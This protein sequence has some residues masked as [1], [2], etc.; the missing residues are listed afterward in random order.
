M[1]PLDADPAALAPEA[2]QVH[3]PRCKTAHVARIQTIVDASNEEARRA[4]LSGSLNA[5]T[6]PA[7]GARWRVDLPLLYHDKASETALVLV[8]Q[9]LNLP[10]DEQEKAIGKLA[11]RLLAELPT[12]SRRMYI[13]QPRTFISEETFRTAVLES[14][15]ISS[16]DLERARRSADLVDRLLATTDE[17]SLDAAL[18]EAETGI[19]Y[20]LILLVSELGQQAAAAG[21]EARAVALAKLRE[22]LVERSGEVIS[23]DRLLDILSEA[24]SADRLVDLVAQL[25]AVLDYEFFAALTQQIEQSTDE[26]RSEELTALRGSILDAIDQVDATARAEIE[27]ATEVLRAV[28]ASPDPVAALADAMPEPTGALFIVLDANV[29]AARKE[30]QDQ[31]VAMLE[32]IRLAAVELAEDR[33]PP[34]ERL[35]NRLARTPEAERQR[36]LIDEHSSVVDDELLSLLAETAAAARASG[37]GE[38]ADSLEQAAELVAARRKQQ[39]SE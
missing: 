19:D 32:S 10:H 3:C 6:C 30:G 27:K 5:A 21:D 17:E 29:D 7:C 37:V 23:F 18:A 20:E 28:L 38:I 11:N 33:L 8:P 1:S 9:A 22:R 31:V 34:R 15:G 13:L 16:D 24:A 35:V 2:I 36:A 39:K 25:R 14:M 4:L 26:E 12:E